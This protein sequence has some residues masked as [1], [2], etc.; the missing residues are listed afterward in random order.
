[1]GA[2]RF[3]TLLSALLR[4]S[5]ARARST[6]LELVILTGHVLL[7]PT[8]LTQERRA[9]PPHALPAT[10]APPSGPTDTPELAEEPT[11][12]LGHTPV[13]LLHGFIDNRSVFV[14][15][16]RSLRRNGW[17][18]V[19]SLNYSPLTCD[20]R[21]AAQLLGRHVEDLCARAGSSGVD[22]VGHSLGGLIARYYIQRLGGDARVRTLVT[23]GTPHGGTR[24]APP[25]SVHPLVRQMRPGSDVIRELAGPAPDCATRFISFWSD[26]DQLMVPV[27]TARIDHP[28]LLARNVR[29]T[30]VGHL[31]LPV[32]WAV[33]A[34][35][36]Q[37][38]TAEE[39]A[40]DAS[41]AASVA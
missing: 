41:G 22:V 32:H 17:R 19:E 21:T 20:V 34:G 35:I 10:P 9:R 11:K 24:V 25:M 30:G 3:L 6:V 12:D 2:L 36:R 5:A 18:H 8:G 33:A 7:Y 39:P 40:A 23:L 27:E 13:L 26:L 38:L 15:L 1:M 14:L 28:D 37:A 29:V 4:P 16:R 31:A